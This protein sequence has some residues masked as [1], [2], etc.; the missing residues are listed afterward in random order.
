MSHTPNPPPSAQPD[1]CAAGKRNSGLVAEWLF[2]S[3]DLFHQ[4]LPHASF[5][6]RVRREFQS[7]EDR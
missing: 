1:N 2:T 5:V 6:H 4:H 3:F 7:P